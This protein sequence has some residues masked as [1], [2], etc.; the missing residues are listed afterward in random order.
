MK[1]SM[2]NLMQKNTFNNNIAE[3][4]I[5]PKYQKKITFKLIYEYTIYIIYRFLY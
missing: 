4:K 2:N 5:F 3:K 1:N